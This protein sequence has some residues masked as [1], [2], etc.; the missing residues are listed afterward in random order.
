MLTQFCIILVHCSV[1]TFICG[2]SWWSALRN[3]VLVGSYSCWGF[4]NFLNYYIQRCFI[5]RPSDSIVSKN[6]GIGRRTFATSDS[7]TIR[8][9]LIHHIRLDFIHNTKLDLIHIIRLDLVHNTRLDLILNTRLD[10]IH[11]TRLDLIYNIWLDLIY[12]TRLDLIK[13][14]C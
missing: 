13:T 9:V 14:L 6:A 10:L 12:N 5:C 11:H 8:L 4:L 2:G 3:Y 7:L 1:C